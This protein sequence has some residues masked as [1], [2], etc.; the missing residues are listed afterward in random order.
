MKKGCL[1]LIF[2]VLIIAAV[3]VTALLG[4]RFYTQQVQ[5]KACY[6]YARRKALPA[7]E[8][9]EFS[10]VVIASSRFHGHICR[11]TDKRT[12]FPVSLAFD[13]PDVPYWSDTLQVM[14]MVAPPLCGVMLVV[15]LTSALAA[16]TGRKKRHSSTLRSR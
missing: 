8:S 9:L 4:G 6:D 15:V 3:C 5:V 12:G 1:Q 10:G 11:F 14:S 7:L 16:E 13:A 2:N